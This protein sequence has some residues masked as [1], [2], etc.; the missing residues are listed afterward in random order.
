MKIYDRIVAEYLKNHEIRSFS[1]EWF[2]RDFFVEPKADAQTKQR[3][4]IVYDALCGKIADFVPTNYRIWDE[5]FPEW[6]EMLDDISV[7]LIVGFPD[8]YDAT[9]KYHEDGTCHIIF[10]LVCWARYVGHCNLS[11]VVQNLLTHEICHVLTH[12]YI[13]NLAADEESEDYLTQLDALSFDEAFAHLLSYQS[14]D[15]DMVD[16]QE[17]KM[18]KIREQSKVRMK[19]ALAET[20]TQRQKRNLSEA[21]C[22]KYD[23]KFACMCGMLYL[24]ELWN[25]GGIP[26][27]KEAFEKG[28]R[29]FAA[30]TVR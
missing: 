30:G 16:W 2:Y 3:V 22:G 7:D 13:K 10:D 9:V 23:E 12:H 15:I 25:G 19:E 26:A 20:D 18:C 27:L 28:H 1:G 29:G 11:E 4:R 8:P 17:E 5:L 21:F 14:R 24:S 6:R